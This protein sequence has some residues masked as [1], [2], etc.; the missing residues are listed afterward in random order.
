MCGGTGHSM[1]RPLCVNGWL[2]VIDILVAYECVS[3][4]Y[5]L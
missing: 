4:H 2:L 3:G 5:E 1:K